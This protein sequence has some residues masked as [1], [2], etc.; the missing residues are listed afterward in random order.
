MSIHVGAS[1]KIMKTYGFSPDHVTSPTPILPK[2][3]V[4]QPSLF[5]IGGS[6]KIYIIRKRRESLS[7]FVFKFF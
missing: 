6:Y 7:H 3:A 5:D 2:Y 4:L 1:L